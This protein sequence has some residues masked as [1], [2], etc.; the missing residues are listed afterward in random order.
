MSL[1]DRLTL[2]AAGVVAVVV[3]LASTATYFVMRHE[4]LGQV[5]STLAAH[6]RVLRFDPNAALGGPSEY[7][8]D[9]TALIDPTGTHGGPYPKELFSRLR[10]FLDRNAPD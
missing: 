2:L 1:R 3:V 4:L 6:A 7:S 8:G 5:D 10:A 9:Y